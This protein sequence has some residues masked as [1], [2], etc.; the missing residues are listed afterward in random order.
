MT[1][2]ST[3]A[4]LPGIAPISHCRANQSA[5]VDAFAVFPGISPVIGLLRE[6]GFIIQQ[7]PCPEMSL[8]RT[9]D[10]ARKRR[11]PPVIA[12]TQ[13]CAAEELHRTHAHCQRPDIT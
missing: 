9:R 5:K 10:E 3:A 7:M 11:V 13:A 4:S 8:D 2:T 1:T 12:H 6:R